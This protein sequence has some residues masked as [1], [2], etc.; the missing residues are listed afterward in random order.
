M[1]GLYFYETSMKRHA[2]EALG[3]SIVT[4][5]QKHFARIDT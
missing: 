4:I 3:H 2:I 1:L 5:V